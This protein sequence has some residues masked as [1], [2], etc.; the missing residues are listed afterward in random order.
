VRAHCLVHEGA[1]PFWKAGRIAEAQRWQE[2]VNIVKESARQPSVTGIA[3]MK[4]ILEAQGMPT[5]GVRLRCAACPRICP[6]YARQGRESNVGRLND[7]Q[8][9]PTP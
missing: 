8:S 6:L 5:G 9:S 7:G 3:V 1:D 4:A 2:R